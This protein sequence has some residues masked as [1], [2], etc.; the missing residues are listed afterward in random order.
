MYAIAQN[1]RYA[2][3]RLR[4]DPAFTLTAVLSL[5]IGIGA[6][7]AVF[8]L[9]KTVLA[10]DTVVKDP[11]KLVQIYTSSPRRTY[12]HFAYPDFEDLREGTEDVFSDLTASVITIGQVDRHGDVEAILGEIVSGSHFPMLGIDAALGRALT[13]EDDVSPG[14]H[15]V[16]MISHGYWKRSFGETPD[17]IG[18]GLRVN[19]LTYIVVGITPEDYHG[20]L[21]GIAPD[22]Y[23]PAMMYDALQAESRVILEARDSSRFFVRGRLEA[24]VTL[25]QA[26][27]AADR[28][29]EEFRRNFGWSSDTGFLVVPRSAVIVYPPLDRFIRASSWLLSAVL[30]LVLLIICT[31]LAGFLLARNLD[32]RR[33][34]ALHL[35]LGAKRGALLAQ[36]LSET[37]LLALAGGALGT[38]VA[39]ALLSLLSRADLPLP[40][41]IH[42]NVGVDISV[43]AFSLALSLMAGLLLGLLPVFQNHRLNLT[44][45]L[46]DE[47]AGGGSSRRRSSVRHALVVTQVAVSLVLLIA[48]G[49]FLRSLQQV[50]AVDP[51]FGTDP[52]AMLT[53]ALSSKRHGEEDG[54]LL[55]QT[56]MNR[57]GEIPGVQHVGITHNLQLRKT[58]RETM[59]VRVDGVDPPP[60]RRSFTVDK[61][62]VDPSFFPAVGIPL[63]RGRSFEPGD[64]TDSQP[65]AIVSATMAESFWPGE[66]ALGRTVRRDDGPPLRI[67]G[68]ARDTKVLDL[69]EAPRP[70]IYLPYAQSYSSSMRII[71]QTTL[72]PEHLAI[73]M[74]ATA[75][76]VDPELILWAPTT[77]KQHLDFVLLPTRLSAAFVTAFAVLAL[78]LASIGLYGI[79]SYSVSQRTR[80]VGIRLSLG[81]NL[82]SLT[83]TLMRSG[84]ALV[85]VGLF[86]GLVASVF[87]SRILRSLLF[88]VTPLDA[89]TFVA[90]PLILTSVATLAAYLAAHRVSHIKPVDALRAE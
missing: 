14:A 40:I 83:L 70:F 5:A 31:N 15:P 21:R 4:K 13:P 67:V 47:S 89:L 6:N 60:E 44:P 19:G 23:A 22:F 38:A 18:Q 68:V 88:H 87:L 27:A 11:D 12:G 75:R 30:F 61:A 17:V 28:V 64:R 71:A 76:E 39:G 16:V 62:Y 48:S 82:R 34:I 84:M 46:K 57:I 25:A 72:D 55:M 59:E 8:S 45:A 65:V 77:M 36:V 9:V 53:V 42:L 74:V 7:V 69:G 79:V 66:S 58:G 32:R 37:T 81:A 43:L 54:R 56:L 41:P 50:Q 3:R 51:G 33:E 78:A 20:S 26:Q 10:R 80:E 35:A 49:L 86:S 63:I 73:Q 1:L 24:G 85:A 2:A 52:A 29:A 90:A